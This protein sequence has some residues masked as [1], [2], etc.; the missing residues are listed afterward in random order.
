MRAVVVLRPGAAGLAQ[1][2][3]VEYCRERLAS[4]KKPESV[5]FTDA[6]PRNPMGK[7]LKRVLQEQYGEPIA[8]GS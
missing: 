8:G 4:F 3:L 5:V 7:V 6:L 1:E 2:E